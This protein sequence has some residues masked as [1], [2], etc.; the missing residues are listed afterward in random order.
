MNPRRTS[1]A[2][3][4]YK[5]PGLQRPP[6][7]PLN[8]N[9]LTSDAKA[10]RALRVLSKSVLN[11]TAGG[12]TFAV[13]NLQMLKCELHYFLMR[14]PASLS[15][16]VPKQSVIHT[17]QYYYNSYTNGSLFNDG[18]NNLVQ[19]PSLEMK[20]YVSS[21]MRSLML[22]WVDPNVDKTLNLNDYKYPITNLTME[23]GGV[24][25]ILNLYTAQDL[26]N[27]SKD[28]GLQSTYLNFIGNAY[29][30]TFATDGTPSF[31]QSVKSLASAPIVLR[32]GISFPLP[33]DISTNSAG[34]Y[35][36]SFKASFKPTNLTNAAGAFIDLNVQPRLNVL[37]IY[38][39]FVSI[40]TDDL[41]CVVTKCPLLPRDVLDVSS[42][43]SVVERE[44]QGEQNK[45]MQE[46]SQ[47]DF[48]G[49]GLRKKLSNRI[50]R[51]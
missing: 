18:A 13:T 38:D 39:A 27:M 29:G 4:P 20:N 51:Y 9:L 40:N 25:N 11:P 31:P 22:V 8:L 2:K 37:C 34:S 10:S 43:D 19:N 24:Q 36:F 50:K 46:V 33:D 49:A 16:K 5:P 7:V 3:W 15:Y 12:V 35:T 48:A 1:G 17:Y 47:P 30:I 6:R 41:S 28:A 14:P 23:L 32:P 26:Y 42:R 44:I 45:P 21:G